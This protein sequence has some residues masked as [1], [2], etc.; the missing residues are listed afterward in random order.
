[1]AIEDRI[2]SLRDR[3]ATLDDAIHSETIRSMPDASKLAELKREKL[4]IKDT[5]AELQR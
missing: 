4:R 5:I 2:R 3:H 1:M